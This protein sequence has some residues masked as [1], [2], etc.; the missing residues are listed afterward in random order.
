MKPGIGHRRHRLLATF[1]SKILSSKARAFG[2]TP[3][4][5]LP[6]N[7]LLPFAKGQLRGNRAHPHPLPAPPSQ[8]TRAVRASSSTHLNAFATFAGSLCS[9]SDHVRPSVRLGILLILGCGILASF[10]ALSSFS[11]SHVFSRNRECLFDTGE[12]NTRNKLSSTGKLTRQK[13]GMQHVT[14]G[15]PH[16]VSA[17]KDS[18]SPDHRSPVKPHCS[19]WIIY[20]DG[21]DFRSHANGE[22]LY[23]DSKRT[24]K[25]ESSYVFCCQQL[26]FDPTR[27]SRP[28]DTN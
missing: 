12:N 27:C 10:G 24:H 16:S 18:P 15:L 2:G 5:P 11:I 21:W 8:Q 6:A 1:G 25:A 3:P 22:E 9:L 4:L 23:S 20:S 28:G 13:V 14:N 19:Y 7:S 17:C 26:L